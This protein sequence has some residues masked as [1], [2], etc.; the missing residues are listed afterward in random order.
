MIV[1]CSGENMERAWSCELVEPMGEAG[2]YE[3]VLI[4]HRDQ[5]GTCIVRRPP[6]QVVL[7]TCV[8]LVHVRERGLWVIAREA[9]V[10]D[11]LH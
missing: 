10:D 8:H 9:S 5:V 11:L 3:N 4:A 2:R 1:R 7:D 6:L